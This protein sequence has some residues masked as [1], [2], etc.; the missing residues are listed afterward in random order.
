MGHQILQRPREDCF[1]NFWKG[2]P[3]LTLNLICG[4]QLRPLI[5]KSVFLLEFEFKEKYMFKV[6]IEAQL[7]Y[8]TAWDYML[9]GNVTVVKM[10]NL[11]VTSFLMCK[12]RGVIVSTSCPCDIKWVNTCPA[13]ETMLTIQKVLAIIVATVLF[14]DFYRPHKAWWKN[15]RTIPKYSYLKNVYS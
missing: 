1:S 15:Y 2:K 9:P 10:I 6:Y 11:L 12:L 13:V 4:F 5:F 3:Y 14:F 8:Q 7:W